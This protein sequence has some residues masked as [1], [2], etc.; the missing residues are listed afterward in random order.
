[1]LDRPGPEN[2]VTLSC[3]ISPK[4]EFYY[5]FNKLVMCSAIAC[6]CCSGHSR[7]PPRKSKLMF[8]CWE[9]CSAKLCVRR[10]AIFNSNCRVHV[11]L[12]RNSVDYPLGKAPESAKNSETRRFVVDRNLLHLTLLPSDLFPKSPAKA[13]WQMKPII[14]DGMEMGKLHTLD[15]GWEI[16][17]IDTVPCHTLI[18]QVETVIFR[19]VETFIAIESR[20]KYR[21][22]RKQIF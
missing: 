2:L 15:I 6:C 18:Y 20:G 3:G 19:F 10:A 13:V 17:D 1:M 16:D 5:A 8:L 11:C 14:R 4:H 12:I 9:N 7:C 21:H 22:A